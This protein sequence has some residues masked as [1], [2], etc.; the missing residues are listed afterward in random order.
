MGG[1][2]EVRDS[3]KKNRDERR[4]GGVTVLEP[5]NKP[6][7]VTHLLKQLAVVGGD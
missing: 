4:R 5:Y 1:N 3:V 7:G 6:D 2:K